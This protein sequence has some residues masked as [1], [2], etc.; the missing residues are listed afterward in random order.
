[1]VTGLRGF[2][3]II[4]F[5]LKFRKENAFGN[6]SFN[7]I[8]PKGLLVKDRISALAVHVSYDSCK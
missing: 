1:M 3:R 8:M 2:G 5:S 4:S 6:R 7:L